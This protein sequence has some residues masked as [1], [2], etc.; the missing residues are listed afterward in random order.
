MK[1]TDKKIYVS[2][3]KLQGKQEAAFFLSYILCD[4]LWVRKEILIAIYVQRSPAACEVTYRVSQEE[5]ARLREGVPYGKAYR[6]NPKHLCPKLK[7]YK[8]LCPKLKGY[9]DNSQRNLKL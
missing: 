8:H 7:G 6:Y 4:S 9:G 2:C 1:E 3:D 5:C